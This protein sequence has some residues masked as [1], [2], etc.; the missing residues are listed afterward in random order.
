MKENTNKKQKKKISTAEGITLAFSLLL[1]GVGIYIDL[2]YTLAYGWPKFSISFIDALVLPLLI[3]LANFLLLL[4]AV[5]KL[6]CGKFFLNLLLI[7]DIF[8]RVFFIVTFLCLF[9]VEFSRLTHMFFMTIP[10]LSGAIIARIILSRKEK[11]NSNNK[12]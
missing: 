1:T 9:T 2:F 10:C 4:I 7:L 3:Y 12:T 6:N 8:L 5:K 11:S